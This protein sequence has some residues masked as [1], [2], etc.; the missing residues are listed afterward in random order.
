VL[1]CISGA[2]LKNILQNILKVL[3]A[4]AMRGIG[5]LR[6]SAY[7]FHRTTTD[8]LE[9]SSML[10]THTLR[11]LLL[12]MLQNMLLKTTFACMQLRTSSASQFRTSS[13]LRQ[14]ITMSCH[15]G[16]HIKAR[17]IQGSSH[18]RN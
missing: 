18:T 4:S 9:V 13:A 14:H 12:G 16:R 1:L 3:S 7:I 11:N 6:R 5:S 2:I 17:N 10:A 15:K 8:F